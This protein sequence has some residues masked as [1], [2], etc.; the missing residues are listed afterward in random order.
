MSHLYFI[1]AGE[2]GPIKIGYSADPQERLAM[3]QVGNHE[4]L[5]LLAAINYSTGSL[6]NKTAAHQESV[7]HR[8]FNVARIRGEWFKPHAQLLLAVE[9][10]KNGEFFDMEVL[11]W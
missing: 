8:V 11:E 4:E 10:L 2:G 9:W 6:G 1:Q 5:R 7:F 3:L